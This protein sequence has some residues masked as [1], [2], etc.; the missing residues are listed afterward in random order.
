MAYTRQVRKHRPHHIPSFIKEIW[1]VQKALEVLPRLAAQGGPKTSLKIAPR[2]EVEKEIE[3][4]RA[5]GAQ[6]I[7]LES[8]LYPP[9]LRHIDSAPPVITVKGHLDLLHHPLFA[10]VGARNASAMGKKM[11]HKLSSDLGKQG[12][13]IASGLARGIDTAPIR[14]VFKPERL[15]FLPA[16]LIIS[17]LEKMKVFTPKLRK[18]AFWLQNRLLAPNPMRPFFRAEIALFQ[19]YLEVF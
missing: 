15:L 9:L 5:Y 13:G 8:P 18:M 4:T 14:P 1:L 6:I 10:I 2:S 3:A 11:A 19:A 7:T 16:E 17:I 12:W